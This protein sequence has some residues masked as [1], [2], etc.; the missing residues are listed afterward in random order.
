MF[1]GVVF[2]CVEHVSLT[3]SEEGNTEG[4][5]GVEAELALRS[6]EYGC[7]MREEDFAVDELEDIEEDGCGDDG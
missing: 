7:V 3:V 2:G 5:D 1:I 6:D 4:A